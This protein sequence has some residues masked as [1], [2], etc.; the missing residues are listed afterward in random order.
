VPKQPLPR[1]AQ[2]SFPDKCH[3]VAETTDTLY[4]TAMQLHRS[5]TLLYVGIFM[6]LGGVFVVA[7]TGSIVRVV[8]GA[9]AA[10]IGV[11]LLVANARPKAFGIGADG[12]T[13]RNAGIKRL[14]TWQEIH[15]LILEQQLQLPEDEHTF[16]PRLLLVPVPGSPLND[17]LD[18]RSP[19][20]NQPCREVLDIDDFTDDAD[21]VARAL[22]HFGG[23]RFVDARAL[24]PYAGPGF[25]VVSGGY[26]QVDV[27]RLVRIAMMALA[28]GTPEARWAARTQLGQPDLTTAILGYDRTQVDAYLHQLGASLAGAERS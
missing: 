19:L 2:P 28:S 27:Q 21:E 23:P 17:R 25:A 7:F 22:A 11:A 4:G 15:V 18:L 1:P 12:L 10:L 8:I 26:R 16:A 6:T 5:R 24:P 9:V 14:V 13:I 3:G 20:D